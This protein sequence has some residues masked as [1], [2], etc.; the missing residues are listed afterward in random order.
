VVTLPNYMKLIP[1][2]R[3]LINFHRPIPL[4]APSPKEGE[5]IIWNL[6]LISSITAIF[7]H[8]I[9]INFW[10]TP[11][12]LRA[13]TDNYREAGNF[14]WRKFMSFALSYPSRQRFRRAHL[15]SN[16]PPIPLWLKDN[17]FDKSVLLN[18]RRDWNLHPNLSRKN[19]PPDI[20]VP[21]LSPRKQTHRTYITDLDFNLFG[22]YQW[23]DDI[24]HSTDDIICLVIYDRTA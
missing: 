21:S 22:F 20:Y 24:N 14:P 19:S 5:W 9:F 17:L 1:N 11:P 12:T 6:P 2:L 8:D 10:G 13:A 18:L 4:C 15:F 23:R 3:L 16:S 7:A